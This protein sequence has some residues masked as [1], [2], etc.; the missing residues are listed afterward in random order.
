MTVNT[1]SIVSFALCAVGL[2]LCVVANAAPEPDARF[3]EPHVRVEREALRA[4]MQGESNKGY[5]LLVSTTAGRF[6]SA[7][8]FELVRQARETRPHG[9]A[10]L[11]HYDDWFETYRQIAELDSASVPEFVALQ[12]THRQS[13]YVEYAGPGTTLEVEKGPV[14][15]QVLRVFAGWPDSAGAA[16][17]Y[18]FVDTAA[19]P[20]MQITNERFITYRL[21]DFGDFVLQDEIQGVR[22]RPMEGALGVAFKVVGSGRAVWSRSAVTPDGLLLTYARARKGPFAVS[23]LSTTLTSGQLL[24]GLPEGREDLLPFEERLKQELELNYA[25]DHGEA[26]TR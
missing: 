9:P 14:P 7:V 22:G 4:A 12:R 13:Q 3:P 17:E 1:S 25:G 11:L 24:K 8:L 18:T 23:I 21:V 26:G 20:D 16:Q 5:N 10:L 19:V 6:T 2:S 15:V